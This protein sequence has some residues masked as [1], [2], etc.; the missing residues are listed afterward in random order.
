MAVVINEME[1]APQPAADGPAASRPAQGSTDSGKDKLKLVIKDI[2]KRH[3]RTA[4]LE[5]Y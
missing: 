5:A 2:H 1:V 4:R 3:Q